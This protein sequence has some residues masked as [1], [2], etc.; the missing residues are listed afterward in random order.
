MKM[1]R[2]QTQ[3]WIIDIQE[4]LLPAME[5][6]ERLVEQSVKLLRGLQLLEIPVTISQQYTRGLGMTDARILAAAGQ[7]AYWEKI[8]FSCLGEPEMRRRLEMF[9]ERKTVVLLG[10]ES[11]ICVLQTALD[12]KTAGYEP[13]VA[14]DC[15]DSRKSQ[16]KEFALRRMEQEGIRLTT[17]EACLFELLERAG[18]DLFRQ[19]SRLIK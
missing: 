4:R 5:Q 15:V 1:N 14:A 6:P 16:D 11:H 10:I 9:P 19:I 17:V 13:V 18:S 8:T 7:E 2:E 3:A 12:L